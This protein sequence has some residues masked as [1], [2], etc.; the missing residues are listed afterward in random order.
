MTNPITALVSGI[1]RSIADGLL[2]EAATPA[3]APAPVTIHIDA[4]HI[5][6]GT[7]LRE[8]VADLQEEI[9][10]QTQHRLPWQRTR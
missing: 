7:D 6:E 4:V 1:L 9:G 3:V 2:A 10:R 5:T 8:L